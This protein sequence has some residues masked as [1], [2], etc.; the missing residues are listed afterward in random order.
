MTWTPLER[1]EQLDHIASASHTRPQLIFK[2]STRCSTSAFVLDRMQRALPRLAP[3]AD[4]YLLDLLA[5]RDI[6]NAIAVRF[7]VHHES[8]QV[9]LIVAGE[10][11]YALS[12]IEISPDALLAELPAATA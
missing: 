9:L 12:H 2:H 7:A 10:C 4:L 11:T 8:P 1:L 5:H 3:L 6:S